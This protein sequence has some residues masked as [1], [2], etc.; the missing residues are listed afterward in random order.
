MTHVMVKKH[1]FGSLE[2]RFQGPFRVL[3]FGFK[4]IKIDRNGTTATVDATRCKSVTARK[5]PERLRDV[6]MADAQGPISDTCTERACAAPT[7]VNNDDHEETSA[8]AGSVDRG[9]RRQ[10]GVAPRAANDARPSHTP[11]HVARRNP[12]RNSSGHMEGATSRDGESS[13]ADV[14]AAGRQSSSRSPLAAA[15][16][17]VRDAPPGQR[18]FAP[19]I[20]VPTAVEL[21]ADGLTRQRSFT[22]QTTVPPPTAVGRSGGVGDR[23]RAF[24]ARTTVWPPTAMGH[25]RDGGTRRPSSTAKS[26]NDASSNEEGLADMT[27]PADEMKRRRRRPIRYPNG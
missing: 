11:P 21:Q 6:Q 3:G 23:Q 27:R 24:A 7:P 5:E 12:G 19:R 9:R 15:R 14:A 17:R 4:T 18:A 26:T 16:P 2:P 22:A 20:A 10:P 1:T 8:P 13:A 25:R